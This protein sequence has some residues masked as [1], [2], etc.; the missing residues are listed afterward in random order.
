MKLS[1]RNRYILKWNGPSCL[2]ARARK[3]NKANLGKGDMLS[4]EIAYYYECRYKGYFPN[5]P[6]DQKLMS[7]A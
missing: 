6:Y 1:R 3:Q 7:K 4:R 2:G 5:V